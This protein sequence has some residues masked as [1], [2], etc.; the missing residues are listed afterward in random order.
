MS[1]VEI[2]SNRCNLFK[3]DRM[4]DNSPKFTYNNYWKLLFWATRPKVKVQGCG[5]LSHETQNMNDFTDLCN[6]SAASS[7]A[8]SST[9]AQTETSPAP[10]TAATPREGEAHIG[11]GVHSQSTRQTSCFIP[12]HNVP[13]APFQVTVAP[14]AVKQH[15]QK[16]HRDWLPLLINIKWG[17]SNFFVIK[18]KRLCNDCPTKPKFI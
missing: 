9:P 3:A 6:L 15:S 1:R 7:P 14:L 5:F 8:P 2:L 4:T 17:E 10:E 11:A 16:P 13:F 12:L 18:N